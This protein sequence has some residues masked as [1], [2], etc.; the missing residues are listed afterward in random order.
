M[1]LALGGGVA[2]FAAPGIN[3]VAAAA[4]IADEKVR[5]SMSI[6]LHPLVQSGRTEDVVGGAALRH[7]PTTGPGRRSH[8]ALP[9]PGRVDPGMSFV[10]GV[11]SSANG[12]FRAPFRR[13]RDV[14]E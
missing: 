8:S 13:D 14:R 6:G 2:A 11:S 10:S 7:E 4:I 9:Y 3:V 1:F 5:R 12:S